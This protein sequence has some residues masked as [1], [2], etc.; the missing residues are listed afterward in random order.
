MNPNE[1]FDKEARKHATSKTMAD[2]VGLPDAEDK[3]R[4][5]RYLLQYEKKHPNEIGA[6][7]AIARQNFRDQGGDVAKFGLV[8]KQAH[9]RTLFE[10]PEELGQWME[11]AYPLMFKEKKHTAWFCKNFP[12]LL[13]PEKY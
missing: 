4:I 7:L 2:A 9:G 3:K 5:Q 12:E 6:I 1:A 13:I 11:Q 8:N 10:L